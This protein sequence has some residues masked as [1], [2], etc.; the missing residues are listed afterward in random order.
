VL[1]E[2][3][4]LCGF[5]AF[6]T[7]IDDLILVFGSGMVASKITPQHINQFNELATAIGH[8]FIVHQVI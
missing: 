4:S 5:L 2:E 6:S 1:K 8:S 3:L 7:Q